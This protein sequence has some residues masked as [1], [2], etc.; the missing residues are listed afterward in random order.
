MRAGFALIVIGV[1]AGAS[2]VPVP[3]HAMV[4]TPPTA[5]QLGP[6]PNIVQVDRRCGRGF[7]WVRGHRNR[8]GH[9][10]RSHCGRNR[11]Y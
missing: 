8:Y 5:E 6:S 10:I 7:H 9:W 1:L 4:M 3:A 11:R 2:I